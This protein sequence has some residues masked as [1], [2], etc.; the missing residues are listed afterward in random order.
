M[1]QNKI[2][3]ILIIGFTFVLVGLIKLFYQDEQ[4]TIAKGLSENPESP[5]IAME[6]NENGDVFVY[7][8]SVSIKKI[9]YFKGSISKKEWKNIKSI[10]E[11]NIEIFKNKTNLFSR[12]A[13]RFEL[14]VNINH[15]NKNI[16]T[17]QVR[18]S[19]DIINVINYY[20]TIRLTPTS[21]HSF[22]TKIQL[23]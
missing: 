21:N 8:D 7:I 13:T 14:D 6:I 20:K 9:S 23:E 19:E 22:K 11:N 15:S 1:V 3:I 10:F 4:I 12:D 18:L 16:T 5:K 2:K 17:E